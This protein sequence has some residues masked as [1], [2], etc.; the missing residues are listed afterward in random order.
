MKLRS[1]GFMRLAVLGSVVFWSNACYTSAPPPIDSV[2]LSALRD[3]SRTPTAVAS[4]DGQRFGDVAIRYANDI[5]PRAQAR[6]EAHDGPELLR[7]GLLDELQRAGLAD[8]SSP[9]RLG[10]RVDDFRIRS[11]IV[12]LFIGIVMGADRLGVSVFGLCGDDN[13]L[14]FSQ[15]VSSRKPGIVMASSQGRFNGIV[16]ALSRRIAR[17]LPKPET[18]ETWDGWR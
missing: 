3:S 17:K 12:N 9:R 11:T 15:K 1:S 10:I 16:K 8:P 2:Y 6:F 18:P 7:R 13:E 14:Q 4:C 5:A